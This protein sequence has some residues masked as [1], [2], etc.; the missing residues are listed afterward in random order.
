MY[1]G[2]EKR[3]QVFLVGVMVLMA[4][5][6]LVVCCLENTW[7]SVGGGCGAGDGVCACIVVLRECMKSSWWLWCRLRCLFLCCSV[8]CWGDTGSNVGGGH[9]DGYG[10]V[11]VS[12]WWW[13]TWLWWCCENAPVESNDEEG[14]RSCC[15]ESGGDVILPVMTLWIQSLCWGWNNYGDSYAMA[16]IWIASLQ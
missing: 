1:F 2:A 11:I 3:L 4:V 8:E 5:L 7:G 15:F 10:V 12:W 13:S 14:E 9:G 16:E 6:V